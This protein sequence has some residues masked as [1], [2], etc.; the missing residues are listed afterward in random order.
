MDGKLR[1][2]ARCLIAVMFEQT[3]ARLAVQKRPAPG[4]QIAVKHVLEECVGEAVTHRQRPVGQLLFGARLDQ[5]VNFVQAVEPFLQS[6][7]VCAR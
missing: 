5:A 7:V 6:Q 3:L 1:G 2:D 4:H